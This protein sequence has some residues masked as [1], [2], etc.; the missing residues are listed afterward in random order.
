MISISIT[1]DPVQG[2]TIGGWSAITGCPILFDKVLIELCEVLPLLLYLI[3]DGLTV[4]NLSHVLS[5]EL[6]WYQIAYFV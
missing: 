3:H 4:V 1:S 5:K 6:S 2:M